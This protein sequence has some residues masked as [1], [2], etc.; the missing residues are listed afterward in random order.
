MQMTLREQVARDLGSLS[1]TDL[2]QVAEYVSF[3][4]FRSRRKKTNIDEEQLAALY[5][6]FADEDRELSESGLEDYAQ[7]LSEEDAK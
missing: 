6:E 2:E 7:S 5:A 4:K 1:D 3:L